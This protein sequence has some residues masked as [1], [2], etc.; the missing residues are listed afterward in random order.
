MKRLL[1]LFLVFV[2]V[3]PV[4]AFADQ[5]PII[6][7]WYMF[8]DVNE[9]SKEL[10]EQGYVF[11]LLLFYFAKDGDIYYQEIDFKDSTS[12]A[13]T[14]NKLGKWERKGSG[15]SLSIYGVGVNDSFIDNDQMYVCFL[16]EK[17]Y[18]LLRKMS[19]FNLYNEIKVK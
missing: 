16:V 14:L 19:F 2:F 4:C 17:T 10:I 18:H 13:D 8:V 11:S 7:C 9:T 6:G 5:D 15:Y 12:E 3:L 1:A